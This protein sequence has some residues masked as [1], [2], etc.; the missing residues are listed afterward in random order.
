M[1]LRSITKTISIKA[2]TNDVFDFI[3]NAENWPRWAIVNVKSISRGEG[4]WWNME[5]PSVP[6][7]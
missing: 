7:S 2:S 6:Q 5:T 4:E 1:V 3:A